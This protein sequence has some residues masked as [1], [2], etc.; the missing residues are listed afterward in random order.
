MKISDN[1][2]EQL[3][4]RDAQLF[5]DLT[6]SVCELISGGS[7]ASKEGFDLVAL[8]LQRGRDYGLPS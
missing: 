8:N 6:D 3:E 2:Q 5:E 4:D 1:N 7:L